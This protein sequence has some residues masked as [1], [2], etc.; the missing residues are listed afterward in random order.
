MNF[1]SLS[2]NDEPSDIF[3][4][5]LL[6]IRNPISI[7]NNLTEEPIKIIEHLSDIL[8]NK[9]IIKIN[10]P[11]FKDEEID[12]IISKLK[13]YHNN[14]IEL[15]KDLDEAQ[16]EYA[17]YMKNTNANI[18]KINSSIQF[19]RTCSSEYENDEKIKIIIDSMLDYI[20]TIKDNDKLEKYKKIYINKRKKLNK[21]LYLINNINN[22]NNSAICPVCI[23]EKIDSYCNPCGHT[24]CKNCLDKSSNVINNTNNTNNNKCPICRE[25][26]MDIRKLYLI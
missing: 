20:K 22:W 7:N 16:K 3:N 18:N 2:Y 15:Q 12:N 25:Y 8:H 21:Y 13:E 19:I 24:F 26:V 9:E 17:D 5:Q 10:D 23:T 14:F 4:N 11:E 1:T 6:N